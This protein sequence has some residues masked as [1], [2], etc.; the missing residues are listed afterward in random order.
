MKALVVMTVKMQPK[1]WG[2][3]RYWWRAVKKTAEEDGVFV[4]VIQ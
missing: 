2:R 1:T 4:V 3:M